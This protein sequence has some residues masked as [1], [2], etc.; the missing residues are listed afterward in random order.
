MR[1]FGHV[2]C[3]PLGALVNRH[4]TVVN[5]GVKQS[6]VELKSHGRGRCLEDY[7]LL[8]LM[9]T[10]RKIEHYRR[11]KMYIGVLLLL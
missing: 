1:W 8:E 5:K 11:E 6:E 9:Q 3:C 2:L 10:W 4:E 7:N